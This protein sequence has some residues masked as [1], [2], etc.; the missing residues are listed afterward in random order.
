MVF[1]PK[2]RGKYLGIGRVEVVWKYYAAVVNCWLKQSVDRVAVVQEGKEP[3]PRYNL[4][5]MHMP[6]GRLINHHRTKRCDRN[7]YMQW[8]RR[9]VAITI[10]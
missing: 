9:D 4:C 10:Q 1:L 8:K 6:A 7:T 2:G 5:N 3:L